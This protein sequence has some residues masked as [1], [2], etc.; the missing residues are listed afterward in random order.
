MRKN[1]ADRGTGHAV[2]ALLLAIGLLAGPL[3][4]SGCQT[5]DEDAAATNVQQ[6]AAPRYV[7][8][9]PAFEAIVAPV[10]EGRGAVTALLGAGQTPHAYEPRPSDAEAVATSRALLYGAS[11]LDGWTTALDAPR[12]IALLDLVPPAQ[13]R[14][15]DGGTDPHFW[16]APPAV[17]ALLP[18]LADT[19]CAADAAG[20]ATYRARADSFAT[21]LDTLDTTLRQ[22]MAPV[23]D[24]PVLLAQPFFHYFTDRYGPRVVGVV[25]RHPGQG[26]SPQA[27]E[28]LVRQA[29]REGVH[30]VVAPVHAPAR[31]AQAVAEAAGVP[32]V[33]VDP[34]GGSAEAATYS[35]LM[36]HCART[37]RAAL[38]QEAPASS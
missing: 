13:Q 1:R 27:I 3:V 8:T 32:L 37:L 25:T 31:A 28:R 35:A 4:G 38:D 10:V 22:V 29:R 5:G 21:V 34:F 20:C 26:P 23:R 2:A 16:T 11:A 7:T 9:L 17:R 18:A 19:L 6:A 14:R 24:V 33:R 36:Q 12:R 15:V 30:A